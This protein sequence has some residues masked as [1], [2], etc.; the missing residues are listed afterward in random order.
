MQTVLTSLVAVCATV[1]G[2]VLSYLFQK[3]TTQRS[4]QFNRSE[5]LR[6]DKITAY[7]R[8]AETVMSFRIAQYDRWSRRNEDRHSDQYVTA[9]LESRRLRAAAWHALYHVRL[10]TDEENVWKRASAAMELAVAIDEADGLE[11]LR[12]RGE[13]TR[14]AVEE[15]IDLAT[16]NIRS[17]TTASREQGSIRERSVLCDRCQ[18]IGGNNR[19]VPH[20]PST[21]T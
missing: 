18:A 5:R 15:F 19:S 11:D 14:Y 8:F 9:R 1:V 3:S 2:A 17:G 12:T 4:E 13:Q 16:F 21:T 10:L 7:S 6:Q 20:Q